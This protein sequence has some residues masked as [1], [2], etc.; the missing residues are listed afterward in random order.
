MISLEL[1]L[2]RPALEILGYSVSHQ[3][4]SHMRLTSEM[5][6]QHHITVPAHDPLRVGTLA[7]IVRDV[8]AHHDMTRD[9]LL[10]RL[11]S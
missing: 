8:A 5:N 10:E 4:G 3:T 6:G 2:R 7:A 11:F 9:Q 1:I